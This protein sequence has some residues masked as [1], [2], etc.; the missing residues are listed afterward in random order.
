MT[1]NLYNILYVSWFVF[2]APL[3]VAV[4]LFGFLAVV[5]LSPYVVAAVAVDRFAGD[6]VII[7]LPEHDYLLHPPLP[8]SSP[9]KPF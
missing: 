1:E 8:P 6:F 7:L 9:N 3:W 2:T 5:G 4:F